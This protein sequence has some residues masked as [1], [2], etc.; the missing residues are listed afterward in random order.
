[1]ELNRDSIISEIASRFDVE[2]SS[3]T[4]GTEFKNDLKADSID[5]YQMVVEYEDELGITLEDEV[6]AAITTVGDLLNAVIK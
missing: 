6:M 2:V 5:L 4:D 3:I 1:M